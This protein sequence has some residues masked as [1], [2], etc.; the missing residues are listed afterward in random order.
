[1][2]PHFQVGVALIVQ[3]G[4]YLITQRKPD[5][6]LGG[7]WEFPGGKCQDGE[8]LAECVSREIL[9]EL[10]I[11]ISQPIYFMASRHEYV[12]KT[13]VLNFFECSILRGRPQAI[14]CAD[15]RWVKPENFHEFEFP[16][17]DIP[18]IHRLC[19]QTSL[20]SSQ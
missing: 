1:M 17:A 18:V 12:E 8:S 11:E 13:V 2:K 14:E 15:F 3:D 4:H 10:D 6:H 20:S 5:V 7:L 16:P 19:M 9:E